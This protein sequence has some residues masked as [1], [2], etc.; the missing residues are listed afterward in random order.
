MDLRNVKLIVINYRLKAL[1]TCSCGREYAS[2]PKAY[3]CK[4]EMIWADCVCKSTMTVKTDATMGLI[5][6]CAGEYSS[7]SLS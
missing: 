2:F 3:I 6:A 7:P 1:H 4:Y 5:L